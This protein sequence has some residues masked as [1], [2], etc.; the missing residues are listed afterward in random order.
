MAFSYGVAGNPP[1]LPWAGAQKRGLPPATTSALDY[2]A[3]MFTAANANF[4]LEATIPIPPEIQSPLSWIAPNP[5][6][7]VAGFRGRQ[8]NRL[9]TLV[10]ECAPTHAR[11]A[12]LAPPAIAHLGGLFDAVAFQQILHRFSLGAPGGFL[13]L[14][15][16]SPQRESLVS[17]ASPPLPRRPIRPFLYRRCGNRLASAFASGLRRR[18]SG[19]PHPSWMRPLLM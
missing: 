3:R 4:P 2:D 7:A 8:L 17:R 5:T 9:T 16:D 12:A 1:P 15:S 11:W 13:S 18:A 6:Q 19:T 10:T 14:P